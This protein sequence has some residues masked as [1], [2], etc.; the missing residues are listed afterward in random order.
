M[1]HGKRN[2]VRILVYSPVMFNLGANLYLQTDPVAVATELIDLLNASA[3]SPSGIDR[4]V[5]T[6]MRTRVRQASQAGAPDINT[7]VVLA[8]SS[9][10]SDD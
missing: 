5:V 4:R 9:G 2:A 3:G 10:V 6:S 7:T 8:R 1:G